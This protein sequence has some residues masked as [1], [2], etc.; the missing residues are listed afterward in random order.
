VTDPSV[1]VAVQARTGSTRLPGKVLAE[2]AGRPMLRLQLD[3][4]AAVTCGPVVVA[5][6]TEPGDDAVADLAAAAGVDVVRGPEA[7]VLGRFGAV[8]DR[9]RPD[10]LVRL[11]GDCP[12]TDPAVVDRV[13]AAHLAEGADYTSNVFP[14]S[15][16]KGLDVEAVRAEALAIAV[17]DAQGP[18]EREHVTPYLYRRP[19]RFRL[20]NVLSGF[21]LGQEW[22]V[23]DTPDDLAS[24]QRIAAQLDD[25]VAASWLDVHHR[26]GTLRGA[27]DGEIH[28]E[29]LGSSPTGSCPWVRSWTARRDGVALARVDLAVGEGRVERSTSDLTPS[30]RPDDETLISEALDRLLIHD[31]QVRL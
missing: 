30:A 8:L 28:L 21:D 7:D 20:A 19:E 27:V 2:L 18:G 6:S 23:V 10:V 25:P 16:P 12:L 4:L 11:T 15:Y 13:V 1:V 3:R 24:L 17:A 29:V 9:Y 26:I 31:E 22:W 5:T 14:R